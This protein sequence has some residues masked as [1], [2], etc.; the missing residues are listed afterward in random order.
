MAEV[1]LRR[2]L[3]EAGIPATVSS[4]GLYE[5]GARATPD[6]V[7][8][9]ADRGLELSGHVSRTITT[10]LVQHADLVI[11]MAREHVREAVLLQ[12][13]ALP[14]TFTLKELVRR[15]DAAGP[16]GHDEAF[17]AWLKRVAEGRTREELLGVGYDDRMDVFDPVGKGPQLYEETAVLLD[18]LLTRLVGLAWP[19]AE[20]VA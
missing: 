8:A 7:A 11:G 18:D 10:E 17:D 13:E 20:A 4:A 1:L 16:R 2:R 15:A 9:M 6:G 5:G 12:P 19:R 14:R 3:A